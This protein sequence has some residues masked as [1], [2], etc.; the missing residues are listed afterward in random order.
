[1]FP[2][3][4]TLNITN[5][6]QLRA[7][8]A[9]SGNTVVI[10]ANTGTN[11]TTKATDTCANHKSADTAKKSETAA[12]K[13]ADTQATAETSDAQD[14]KGES[15]AANIMSV[16]E[17]AALVKSKVASAGREAVVSLLKKYGSAKASEIAADKLADF[18]SELESL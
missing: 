15:S 9:I 6:D 14:K 13:P 2:M 1:M 18:D 16:D 8:A 12:T 7:L 10:E 3:T 4:I 5:A 17:R 11:K